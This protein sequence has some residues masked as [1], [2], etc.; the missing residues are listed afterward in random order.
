MEIAPIVKDRIRRRYLKN[1]DLPLRRLKDKDLENL[2]AKCKSGEIIYMTDNP[3]AN[4]EQED[5]IMN[6]VLD[7]F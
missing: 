7:A 6:T 3:K 2:A 4:I 1:L 5:L